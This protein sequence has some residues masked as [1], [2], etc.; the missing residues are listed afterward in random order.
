MSDTLAG[1]PSARPFPP[2]ELHRRTVHRRAVEA[3]V[4]GLPAVNFELLFRSLAR[5]GGGWNEVAYWSRL[6]DWKIQTLT[7]N[8]DVIYLYPFFNTKHVGPVVIEVPPASETGSITGSIDDAWQCALED[9]GPAGVDKGAGGK[10]L[11]LSPDHRGAVPEGHIALPSQTYTGYG[12]FRSNLASGS[13]ADVAKAVA[14]GKRIKVY[15]LSAAASPPETRFIDAVDAIYDNVIPYDARFFE[16]LAEFVEREPWIERDKALIDTLR[17]I[18]IGK[19]TRFAPDAQT[20]AILADAAAEAGAWLD[21]R[22][23]GMFADKYFAGTQWAVPALPEVID[24]MQSFFGTPDSYPVD[25]RGLLYSYIY[26][27]AKHLGA[28]QFYVMT[29]KD[30]DGRP[31]DGAASYRLTVPAKA[32]VRLYWSATAYDRATH[33]PIR[34]KPWASRSSLSPGLRTNPD[35]S[36]DLMF[37]PEVPAGGEGNWVP[38]GREGEFEILF[39]FYGPEEPL[40]NKSWALP[41]VEKIGWGDK[42]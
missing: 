3:V 38:T 35:G 10:Y 32:P 21:S 28:G 31:F 7:P 24:G 30:R 33:A 8:P 16:P 13:E 6:P 18:G 5:L 12:I 37:G 14:Y 25:G 29:I 22:Y 27:S 4:W 40:F 19:G 39:R 36:V 34:H 42:P 1:V 23:D 11:I 41:D 17:S 20:K 2:D 15:P 26:F 9:V